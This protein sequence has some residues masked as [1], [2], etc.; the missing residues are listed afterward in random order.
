MKL[1]VAA[2]TATRVVDAHDAALQDFWR[3]AGIEVDVRRQ[4]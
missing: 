1:G 2:V 3:T 4:D